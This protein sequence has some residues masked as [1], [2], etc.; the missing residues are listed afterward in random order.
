MSSYHNLY[1]KSSLRIQ[2]NRHANI[3][4]GAIKLNSYSYAYPSPRAQTGYG[5]GRDG[6]LGKTS[7]LPDKLSLAM[8]YVPFQ[9]TFSTY[10]EMKALKSGTLFP[11]LDKPFLGSGVR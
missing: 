5:T 7:A 8:A 9:T 2:Y 3:V 10:D 11:C 1:P 4:K 6:I